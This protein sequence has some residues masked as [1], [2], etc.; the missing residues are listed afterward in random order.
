MAKERV[1]DASGMKLN[2]RHDKAKADNGM[3]LNG[4]HNGAHLHKQPGT[5]SKKGKAK[6]R[7]KA[8]KPHLMLRNYGAT[9]TK[10]MVT[11]RIGVLRTPI[12]LADRLPNQAFGVKR[13]KNTATP[14]TLAMP[15]LP[16]HTKKA[17][18]SRSM[19]KAM[20]KK[21]IPVIETGKARTSQ[22][23]TA[24]TKPPL[25]CMKNHLIHPHHKCHGGTKTNLDPLAL[26]QELQ[27]TKRPTSSQR[28]TMTN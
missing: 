18:G 11:A 19:V 25:H 23:D 4:Y 14:P 9:S 17:K 20:A 27:M 1:R 24:L 13:V 28:T 2:G 15:T 7:R 26:Q 3:N 12:A 22:L 21:G 8:T 5:T 10:N 16:A 6:G